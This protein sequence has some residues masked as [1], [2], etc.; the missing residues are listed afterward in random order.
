METYRYF[1]NTH[2][3][4]HLHSSSAV[5]C[6]Q[7]IMRRNPPICI[8]L[9]QIMCVSFQIIICSNLIMKWKTYRYFGNIPTC[10]VLTLHSFSGRF[11]A[12][13]RRSA[14]CIALFLNYKNLVSCNDPWVNDDGNLIWILWKHIL[15]CSLAFFLS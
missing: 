12:I 14:L 13:I 1:G 5:A 9:L 3:L 15:V 11:S 10:V 8:V 4:V 6:S 2:L 7:P